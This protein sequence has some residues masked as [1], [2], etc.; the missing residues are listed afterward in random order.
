MAAIELS[1]EDTEKVLQAIEIARTTGKIK[2]G[3]NEVTKVIE[4]GEA[5]LVAI[6]KDADPAEIVMH[7][8]LLGEEKNIKVFQIP[9]KEDLGAAAGLE[10]KTVAVA[11]IQEGDAKKMVKELI[12]Q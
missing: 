7:L 4:R 5:K 10:V 11:I 1:K 3:S 6:A 8:P 2:K 9:S 12:E